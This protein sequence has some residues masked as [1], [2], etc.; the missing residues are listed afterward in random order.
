[1]QEVEDFLIVIRPE[2]VLLID[3][4]AS[5]ERIELCL[6]MRRIQALIVAAFSQAIEVQELLVIPNMR[7]FVGLRLCV[8]GYTEVESHL[9]MYIAGCAA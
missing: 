7:S 2:A 8:S 4:C 6:P 3:R 1:V 9:D 5:L